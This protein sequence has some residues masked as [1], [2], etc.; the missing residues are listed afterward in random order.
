MSEPFALHP[1]T[2][3][4]HDREFIPHVLSTRGVQPRT[5]TMLQSLSHVPG[6]QRILEYIPVPSADGSR[7]VGWRHKADT[8]PLEKGRYIQRA[9]TSPDW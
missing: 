9:F 7:F 2:F 1:R 6:I 5:M 3:L 8:W 4:G